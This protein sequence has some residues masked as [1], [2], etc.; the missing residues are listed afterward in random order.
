M[1]QPDPIA[2]K[3]VLL[4]VEFAAEE[5]GSLYDDKPKGATMSDPIARLAA[6]V[7]AA[8]PRMAYPKRPGAPYAERDYVATDT[9]LMAWPA[10][11]RVLEEARRKAIGAPYSP[12]AEALT[13]LKAAVPE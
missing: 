1:P 5:A 7:E 6:L 11:R 12:L 8:T 3:V 9:I 4:G 2:P 13:A 10:I